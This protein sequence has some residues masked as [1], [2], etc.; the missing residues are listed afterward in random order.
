MAHA[1]LVCSEC[2]AELSVLD[3][4]CPGC[5][6]AIERKQAKV[7]SD[8]PKASTSAPVAEPRRVD[9]K[10]KRFEPW[11]IVAGLAVVALVAFFV[12]TEMQREHAGVQPVAQQQAAPAAMPQ[13]PRVEIAPLEQA[14]AANPKDAGSLL[15]LANGLHDNGAYA[16]AIEVYERYLAIEPDNPDARVDMGVCYFELGR[17]DST[18]GAALLETARKE[19]TLVLKKRPDHQPAAFNLG[20]VTLTMGDLETSNKWFKRAVELNPSSDLGTRAKRI[21][22]QHSVTQ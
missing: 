13:T 3:A 2:G 16:R 9:G 4:I 10:A 22:E 7:R 11:Q 19:M 15:R 21:L 5:G 18:G 20:I 17:L 8:R 12:Y 1:K 6:A 14:A